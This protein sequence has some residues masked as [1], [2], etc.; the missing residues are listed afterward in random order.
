M[1]RLD[2]QTLSEDQKLLDATAS[3]AE[4]LFERHL[5]KTKEWFPHE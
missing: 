3:V 4:S 1:H 2:S 5:A